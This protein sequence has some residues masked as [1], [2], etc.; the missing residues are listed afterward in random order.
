[1]GF[2]TD[3]DFKDLTDFTGHYY[4]IDLRRKRSMVEGRLRAYIV[5]EGYENFS[6]YFREVLHDRSGVEA[7]KLIN[8]LSTNY[9]YFMREEKHFDYFRDT[10]LPDLL[11]REKS[12]DLRIWSAGCSSGEEAYTLAMILADY[13]GNNKSFWDT[14]ILA[15]DISTRALQIASQAI[16]EPDQLNKIPP[17][18]RM[19]FFEPIEDGR[20]RVVKAL[21]DEVIFRKFNLMEKTFPFRKQMHVIFCR[22]VMIYFDNKTKNE[23]VNRFYDILQPG[24]YLLVSLSESISRDVSRFKYVM[25][26]VYRKE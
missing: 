23:V 12:K 25:P 14:C 3:S 17:N 18:W 24:G 2:L 11:V 7:E 1:M 4:G 26:S 13:F 5:H 10:I 9:T 8:R 16:Y 6:T 15:T 19:R 21:R 22:N 20:S